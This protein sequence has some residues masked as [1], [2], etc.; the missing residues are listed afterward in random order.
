MISINF[1]PLNQTMLEVIEYM[2]QLEVLESTEK[3]SKD[4]KKMDKEKS[5]NITDKSKNKSSKSQKKGKNFKKRKRNQDSESSDDD[6]KRF[7]AFCHSN[8]GPYWTHNTQDC[9]RFKALKKSKS[10][11]KSYGDK[12]KNSNPSKELNALVQAQVKKILQKFKNKK[13]KTSSRSSSDSIASHSSSSG[14]E[15]PELL[16]IAQDNEGGPN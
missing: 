7:C 8:D 6:S 4:S 5:E 15:W 9:H 1:E 16:A 10:H 12:K 13:R 2:E 14:K 3:K 11:N